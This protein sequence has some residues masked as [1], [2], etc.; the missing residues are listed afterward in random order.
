MTD[1]NPNSDRNEPVLLYITKCNQFEQKICEMLVWI[2]QMYK[3]RKVFNIESKQRMSKLFVW[4]KQS[5]RFNPEPYYAESTYCTFIGFQEEQH[6]V[7]VCTF[8]A[9]R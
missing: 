4:I 1:G 7:N 6:R 5:V 8:H 3:L 2:I 9:M